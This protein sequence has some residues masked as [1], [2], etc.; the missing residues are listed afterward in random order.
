[1]FPKE[2]EDV[3]DDDDDA[4][5]DNTDNVDAAI[6]DEA[7]LCKSSSCRRQCRS[8]RSR[9]IISTTPDNSAS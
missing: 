9:L 2:R 6:D 8:L 7:S 5:N 3:D 4:A 1:M